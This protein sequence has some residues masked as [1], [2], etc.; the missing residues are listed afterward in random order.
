MQKHLNLLPSASVPGQEVSGDWIYELC[1]I[2][3]LLYAIPM[4]HCTLVSST[5]AETQQSPVES[6]YQALQQTDTASNWQKLAG[7]F[8]WI[9]TVGAAVGNC[10]RG[11]TDSQLHVNT[12]WPHRC[13][14]MVSVRAMVML[15]FQHPEVILQTQKTV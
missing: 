9:S 4:L 10:T 2:A 11:E 1:R 12:T 7:V 13:L 3:S 8:Y 14:T 15:I 5:H 6:L